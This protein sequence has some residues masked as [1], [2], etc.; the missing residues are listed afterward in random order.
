MDIKE[1]EREFRKIDVD[2]RESVSQ[3]KRANLF[4]EYVNNRGLSKISSKELD[5]IIE[6][7]GNDIFRLQTLKIMDLY[8]IASSRESNKKLTRITW[9]MF[10]FTFITTFVTVYNIFF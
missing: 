5:K 3:M 8:D 9:L 6:L 1:F 7:Y 10:I 2:E 4:Y